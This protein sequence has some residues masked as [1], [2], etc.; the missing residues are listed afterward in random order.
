MGWETRNG[1][2]GGRVLADKKFNPH[3]NGL[4]HFISV[5]PLPPDISCNSP[6]QACGV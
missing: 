4:L 5:P 2:G 6:M 1:G 3:N